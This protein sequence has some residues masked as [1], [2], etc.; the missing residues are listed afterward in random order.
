M[1][2][3]VIPLVRLNIQYRS[4]KCLPPK[5]YRKVDN[6][7]DPTFASQIIRNFIEVGLMKK[8]IRCESCGSKR[9]VEAHHPNYLRPLNVMWLCR[10]CHRK[11][12]I[13]YEKKNGYTVT[14]HFY[15]NIHEAPSKQSYLNHYYRRR[16]QV[17]YISL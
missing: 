9:F 2:Q 11:W 15:H 4:L 8:R 1:K 3:N 7:I 6:V 17:R 16:S 5:T 12:H 13:E 10:K 14:T